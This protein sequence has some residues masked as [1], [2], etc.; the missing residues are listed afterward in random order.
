M[1]K[2]NDSDFGKL[3]LLATNADEE[4]LNK[5]KNFVN[6]PEESRKTFT[7]LLGVVSNASKNVLNKTKRESVKKERKVESNKRKLHK[8]KDLD[9]TGPEELPFYKQI[10][11]SLE[12]FKRYMSPKSSDSTVKTYASQMHAMLER[13][14]LNSKHT[15]SL[16]DLTKLAEMY[17]KSHTKSDSNR[18]RI[19]RLFN[20]YLVYEFLRDKK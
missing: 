2:L 20:K 13:A 1:S 5:L 12:R 3:I 19:I 6:L 15:M 17:A 7:D 18:R 16:N 9:I 14:A 8:L 11:F 10:G 4:Q